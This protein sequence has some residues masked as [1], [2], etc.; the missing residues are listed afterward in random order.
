MLSPQRYGHFWRF[1][2]D[3][4]G[5]QNLP[6]S[7][8]VRSGPLQNHFF[9]NKWNQ[10]GSE[11]R[12][13]EARL[14]EGFKLLRVKKQQFGTEKRSFLDL[15]HFGKAARQNFS[16]FKFTHFPPFKW[17]FQCVLFIGYQIWLERR[18]SRV[19]VFYFRSRALQFGA[20][21][22]VGRENFSLQARGSTNQWYT[23]VRS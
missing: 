19:S 3:L 15:E 4:G 20:S 21:V 9:Q 7:K 11:L 2:V 1:G 22:D 8:Q 17:F 23:T 16:P 12:H 10:F 5:P 13:E 14:L 18:S 6:K